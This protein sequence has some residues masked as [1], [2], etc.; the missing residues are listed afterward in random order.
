MLYLL[1]VKL[2]RKGARKLI[3]CIIRQKLGLGRLVWDS[4]R[5]T[6][7]DGTD[8]LLGHD[9]LLARSTCLPAIIL[10]LYCRHGLAADGGIPHD[11]SAT[12]THAYGC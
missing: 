4:A 10:A 12:S 2:L 9:Q 5:K 3:S 1:L 7:D 8:L 11:C 6:H